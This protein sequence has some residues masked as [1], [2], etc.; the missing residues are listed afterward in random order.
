M[1]TLDLCRAVVNFNLRNLVGHGI[2]AT[3]EINMPNIVLADVQKCAELFIT[4]LDQFLLISLQILTN[5]MQ[6]VVSITA[7]R[8]IVK[9]LLEGIL[10]V[11]T[12]D[13]IL[14]Q[15]EKNAQVIKII[16]LSITTSI[17]GWKKLDK[18]LPLQL[19][20][21]C[22]FSQSAL[23]KGCPN[24]NPFCYI[25]LIYLWLF[26]VKLV[27]ILWLYSVIGTIYLWQKYEIETKYTI[28]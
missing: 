9:I 17:K 27:E 2:S 24:R 19:I 12:K 7:V 6:A 15:M 21:C 28:L 3:C 25:R 13:I 14:H 20:S 22:C 1:E 5:V 8:W 18:Q 16:K 10:A 11:A 23:R 26:C 4:P